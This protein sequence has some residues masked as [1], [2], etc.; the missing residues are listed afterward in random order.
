MRLQKEN[1]VS[2]EMEVVLDPFW[3]IKSK[4]NKKTN[5]GWASILEI[6]GN[7]CSA[8]WGPLMDAVRDTAM[9]SE[10]KPCK[11]RVTGIDLTFRG[12]FA[13]IGNKKVGHEYADN[14]FVCEIN[15]IEE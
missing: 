2:S 6:N 12:R 5:D 15:L 7:K 14:L 3:T 9:I 11:F 13:A 4:R 8:W 1:E 10:P